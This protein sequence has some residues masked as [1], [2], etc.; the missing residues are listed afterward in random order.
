MSISLQGLTNRQ[1]METQA[2]CGKN[3]LTPT[4]GVSEW[5]KFAKQVFGGF[6]LLL[7]AGSLLCLI[8]YFMDMSTLDNVTYYN[9]LIYTS[10]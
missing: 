5:S 6:Q 1:A 7:W 2:R 10:W 4:K 3:K 8:A 9:S